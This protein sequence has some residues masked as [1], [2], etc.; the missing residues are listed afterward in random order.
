V[1]VR[2]LPAVLALVFAGCGGGAAADGQTI[3]SLTVVPVA[4]RGEP[5]TL[6]GQT[7]DSTTLDIATLRGKV[8][9]LN[10]WGSWCPPC[11]KEA[12]ELERAFLAL[13]P[14]GVEF[15]GIDTRDNVA[16]ANAFVRR[17]EITYP[18]L[19]DDGQMLLAFRGAVPASAVPT[20]LVLD[21]RGRIAARVVGGTDQATVEGS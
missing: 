14:R 20:T 18:S 16:A 13:H 11:R 4:R 1:A 5:V 19:V 17:Y 7:L 12:P 15:V 3:G 21:R 10:V 2:A 9:V 8:V 6:S